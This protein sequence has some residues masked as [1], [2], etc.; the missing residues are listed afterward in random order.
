MVY[1]IGQKT[2]P[3]A[4]NPMTL[5]MGV[6]LFAFLLSAIAAPFFSSGPAADGLRAW[7]S[8]PV[9]VLAVGV[10]LIEI[11]FLLAYRTGGALQWSGAAVNGAAALILIPIAVYG[12]SESF[13]WADLSGITLV[14]AGLVLL[15]R[16]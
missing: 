12:F 3:P 16:H 7:L 8:W 6:Y 10:F 2:L 9:V 5:L 1:H 13:S 4:A 11:G 14:I 15:A